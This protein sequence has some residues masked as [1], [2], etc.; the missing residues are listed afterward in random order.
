VCPG[1]WDV[2]SSGEASEPSTPLQRSRPGSC[3]ATTP[4]ALHGAGAS[5]GAAPRVAAASLREYE[6][7]RGQAA[8]AVT[9]RSPCRSG[10]EEFN[11]VA[12]RF[13]RGMEKEARGQGGEAGEGGRLQS[14]GR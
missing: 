1:A 14:T 6:V 13:L 10:S 9:L 7:G 12:A 2:Q 4:C 3:S 8:D 5:P 11:E